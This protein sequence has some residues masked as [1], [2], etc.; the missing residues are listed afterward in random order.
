[1]IFRPQ[2]STGMNDYRIQSPGNLLSHQQLSSRGG[3]GR[4][5]RVRPGGTNPLERRLQHSSLRS[6]TGPPHSSARPYGTAHT[7]LHRSSSPP[8]RLN[9]TRR[10]LRPSEPGTK[11]RS[12]TPGSIGCSRPSLS[13]RIPLRRGEATTL[14]QDAGTSER[15]SYAVARMEASNSAKRIFPDA[16]RE[17]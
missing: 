10:A 1:M 6:T 12:P 13:R 16:D 11:N 3:Q 14:R 9:P 8:S 5:S 4:L 7:L 2:H 17:P 15:C